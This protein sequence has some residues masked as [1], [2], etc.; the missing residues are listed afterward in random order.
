M[1]LVPDVLERSNLTKSQFGIWTGQQLHPATPLYNVAFA[2]TIE[3]AIERGLFARALAR[4]LDEFDALRTVIEVVDGVPRQRVLPTFEHELETIDL[5]GDADPERAANR[6]AQERCQR[7]FDLTSRLFD[8][9]LIELSPDRFVWYFGQH[10]VIS[11][12]WSMSLVFTRLSEIYGALARQ[13]DLD[14]ERPPRF[15][16]YVDL[17]RAQRED[18]PARRYW[19]RYAE[20]DA[21]PPRLYGRA[22]AGVATASERHSLDL[23]V[24][25]SQAIR[26]FVARPG[27]R[28][29]T[30]ELGVF[31]L[32]AT[33]LL[34]YQGRVSGRTE[35]GLG[36]L[37][38]NRPTADLRRTPGL[39]TE[40]FPLGIEIDPADSFERVLAKVRVETQGFLM[41]ARGGA[42]E[43]RNN[44]GF[45]TVL[46][47]I[48]GTFREFSGMQV[49]A[50]WLHPGH[51]DREHALRVHVH[52]F[53]GSGSY[54]LLFDFN[55]DVF[56][57]R[58]QREAIGHFL[59][60]TD[61]V[62]EDWGRPLAEVGL[63][64]DEER[65]R[66]LIGFNESSQPSST[67]GNVVERFEAQAAQTPEAVALSCGEHR[68]CADDEVTYGE[69]DAAADRLA[70]D[71]RAA[72]VVPGSATGLLMSRSPEAVVAMLGILK[73]GASYVPLDPGWP[74]PR[75]R[76][77]L[78]D[79][80]A[81]ILL[82]RREEG[83]QAP[84]WFEGRLLTVD[85]AQRTTDAPSP[86]RASTSVAP[87]A[88]AYVIYTSGSTGQPKG[89]VVSH[90]ALANYVAWACGH[91]VGDRRLSFPFYSPMT[92]DLTVTS[93]FVP[94][95]SGGTVVVYPESGDGADL[96]LLDVV[97]DD[98][99]D[100][101]KLTPSHLSLLG[102]GR[103]RPS[104]ARQLIFGGEALTRES[105]LR[106]AGVFGEDVVIHNEYGPTEATVGCIV[107]T[108]DRRKDSAAS[109][110][111]GKPIA[112]MKAYVLGFDLQP[113]P[114]G[115]VGALYVGGPGLA[116]GYLNRPELTA[117]RYVASPFADGERLYATGDLARFDASGNLEYSGRR[118]EQVK[119]RG[120]RIELGEVEAAVVGHSDIEA[121]AVDV[122]QSKVAAT[123]AMSYCTR[124]AMPSN[125]P[126]IRFDSAGVCNE[127]LAFTA[128][129]ARAESYFKSPDDLRALLD[130]ARQRPDAP[131]DCLAL[132][133]GGKDST[134]VLCQLVD[135]GYRV[136]AFTLDNGFISDQAKANIRRVV[137]A[138]G[139]D[140][141][142]GETPAMNRIFVDSLERHANVCHGCFK[143]IYTLSMQ[144][145]R[146]RR[147]P[148]IVTGLSR[149]QFFE[150]RLT[151]E[152]F[153]DP[154]LEVEDIDSIVLEARKAYHRVDDAVHQLLDVSMFED[155]AVFEEVRFLDF[156][157][158]VPVDL[159]ELM[160]YLDARVPWVRPSDTGRSTN[161]LINDTG[162]WVHQRERG[163]HNYALPY[164]W[165]VRM[166]HK[167]R[168][169]ALTELQD[170]IDAAEV[171][172][173]LERI[174]YGGE[175]PAD[176]GE[177]RLVAY[178]TAAREIPAAELR[179]HLAARLPGFMI[180]SRFVRL[181]AIP[182]TAHG[183]VDRA[184]LD[185]SAGSRPSL[186]ETFV[187]PRTGLE[188]AIARIW[189]EVL[190]V[191]RVG[192]RDDFFELGGDSIMA[193]QIVAR[194]HRA[195]LRVTPA[196]LFE[197]LNVGELARVCTA[198]ESASEE[199]EPDGL[200]GMT[201]AQHWFLEHNGLPRS[202]WN[203]VLRVTAPSGV[204]VGRME[205]ALQAVFDRHQTLRLRF[206]RTDSSVG[207]DV[208]WAAESVAG[209]TAP[210]LHQLDSAGLAEDERRRRES[211]FEKEL[212]REFDLAEAPLLRIGLLRGDG[213]ADRLL[214]VAHHLIVD[215]VSWPLLL[216]DLEAAYR[217]AE[218]G[219]S[220]ALPPAIGIGRWSRALAAAARAETVTDQADHWRT[221]TRKATARLPVDLESSA[222]DT[223]EAADVVATQLSAELTAALIDEVPARGRARVDEVLIA[224]LASTLG[225]WAEGETLAL[226]LE[227][228]GR[229]P[230][231]E[232]PDPTPVVGWLGSIFPVALTLGQREPRKILASVKEELRAAPTRGLGYGLLRYLNPDEA[233]RRRGS[234][235]S[236]DVL[237]NY[238]GRMDRAPSEETRLRITSPLGLSRGMNMRRPFLLEITALVFGGRLRIE[239]G[240]S[241]HRHRR[242]TMEGRAQSYLDHVAT[243]VDSCLGDAPGDARPD[244]FPLANLDQAGL[245]KLSTVLQ[246]TRE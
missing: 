172:R 216:D 74:E 168:E 105:A 149:G 229:E 49:R 225:D 85:L 108:F 77:V 92:F 129:A 161:C 179:S 37:S 101:I 183:K 14:P 64:S 138:L 236:S 31:N 70:A 30:E 90:S 198:G 122:M 107:H 178:Y 46:N 80:R 100:V 191:D 203:H 81:E 13:A 150:T 245:S 139:V 55:S 53:A 176:Q 104:R 184:A 174:G 71:L 196:Q 171:Q 54:Q 226:F 195:G 87:E 65:A 11:D 177:D 207:T 232:G 18:A 243:L 208:A 167:R 156:Y 22:S 146:D 56:D 242:S 224:A 44:R 238:L 51:H 137:E 202:Q 16:T 219:G 169:S 63:L 118:D 215:A 241:R 20:Q 142:F 141:V 240:F 136:L 60:L 166:G 2:F 218:A 36:A 192:I 189:C 117:A 130:S 96:A 148:F 114:E 115:V 43:A 209:V 228:H 221:L 151:E 47:F 110:P 25:R 237:F 42:S 133:S 197:T 27:A 212:D 190:Q 102:R 123:G 7:P 72:G 58:L 93:I 180:P 128:Y 3:G 45:N 91:Y 39:F 154:E 57:A 10:H 121:C 111:I 29:L 78:E 35:L 170:V 185:S 94:L 211:A 61:A 38:H 186:A 194:C 204:D 1:D 217:Q 76:L 15:S 132:L 131:Y 33:L 79:C 103:D 182:M 23:G 214:F 145:A 164:S 88:P 67:Y 155:D 82:T 213:A 6:V 62:L 144:L 220:A 97:G 140:H 9:A 127:C 66:Q 233:S 239:W 206:L 200:V 157:R 26:D 95:T 119:I 24:E 21:S 160:R 40:V 188:T 109:V 246:R 244:D 175:M 153:T 230:L 52:D 75:V 34:A 68:A 48:R 4:V 135:M 187:A 173:I 50:Q 86:A 205:A 73:A 89:V 126:G 235:P 163:F 152:L 99:V 134:Y 83:R 124:C 162:I 158:Y 181:E 222:V 41:H 5:S 125:Y 193:I 32:M 113:V 69:L 59:K 231:E 116:R 106:A 159:D 120:A 147:I 28:A 223:M 112:G 201:S 210:R 8:T 199:A 165:D 84:D 143:T 12:A 227:G 19:S 17:E 234:H 98:L